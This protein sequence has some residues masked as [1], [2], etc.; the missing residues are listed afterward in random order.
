MNLKALFAAALLVTI[1][2]APLGAAKENSLPASENVIGTELAR[3]ART[4]S[5][6]DMT[7]RGVDTPGIA[8]ARDYIA[9]EFKKYGLATAGENSYFQRLEVTTGVETAGENS[10]RL[11][12]LEL[13]LGRDWTP[14]GFSA[15]GGVAGEIIFAGYGI[16]AADYA[17]DDYSGID[18]QGKIVLALRYEPPPKDAASPFGKSGRPS[19]YAAFRTKAAN[20]HAHGARALVLVDLSSD[21]V[22][23]ELIP[24]GHS[25]GRSE[26]GFIAIQLRRQVAEQAL[27]DAGLPLTEIKRRIDAEERPHSGIVPGLRAA[28]TVNLK[29]TVRPSDNVVGILPGSDPKLK[30]ES[31]VI[32]AHYDHLGFGH[33]GTMDPAGEGQIHHGAD[34]NASGTAVL[35]SLAERFARLR[36]GPSRTIV[37][38][39]FTGEELG[40]YGSKYF[41]DHPPV[42]IA[43]ARAMIN[44]DMVGRMK[45]NRLMVNSADSAAELR[46]MMERAAQGVNIEMKATG[47]GSD[48]VSFHD[49]N[50]PAV[51]FYTGMHEDYHR[52]S[53]TWEKL[54]VPGMVKVSDIVF[55]FAKELAATREP[56]TFVKPPSRRD[57]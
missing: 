40:L 15:S 16:T 19:R 32:G 3:H 53:D 14:L 46:T 42:P 26:E 43:S 20:A 56:L 5:A 7:G 27:G 18:A 45:D 24:L 55:A 4:L 8:K 41:A 48:H 54:N 9:A 33:Y 22:S 29:K 25:T 39:A 51:H 44:L 36:P 13:V 17:Y 28:L 12:E 37:F 23:D 2:L 31:I 34:D 10:A 47:G 52:P 35:L 49:K 57:G 30:S 50:I 11:G 21:G 1:C 38:V 6:D